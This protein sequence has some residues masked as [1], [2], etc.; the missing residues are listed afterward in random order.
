VTLTTSPADVMTSAG[1][2][3]IVSAEVRN[4][5]Q[6]VDPSPKLVWRSSNQS[7]AIVS[8]TG[9][10][11]TIIAV[12]DGTAT[13]S[14][15]S[16]SGMGT[17]NVVV[18][19]KVASIDIAFPSSVLVYGT[20]MQLT[21]TA[22]DARH[23]PINGVTGF[24]YDSSDPATI[25]VSPD[26]V[27]TPVFQYNQ[28]RVVMISATATRDGVTTSA[29]R[30]VRV[31]A[32][33][34]YDVGALMLSEYELPTRTPTNGAGV[35]YFINEGNRVSYTITW[36]GLSGPSLGAHIHGPGSGTEV[37]DILVDLPAVGQKTN[38]GSAT[39]SIAAPNI[40][41]QN[42]QPPISLD[43][44]ITLLGNR[45]AYVD[46]HTAA[47]FGGDIRGQGFFK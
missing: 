35:A 33:A 12:G 28:P 47:Y 7:V 30:A 15:T 17:I 38:Y 18:H 3:L 1:D 46:V 41:S 36:S 9:G 14:A 25:V 40:H 34:T 44:L 42:G 6:T 23:N 31:G 19:R 26:R 32:P 29:T 24:T 5:D 16:E 20:T 8:D 4:G 21:A 37:G 2:T 22:R 43:S 45:R 39:G 11:G 10:R 13:I 27:L